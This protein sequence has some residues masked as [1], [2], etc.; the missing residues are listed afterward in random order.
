MITHLNHNVQISNTSVPGVHEE[1]GWQGSE[2][3]ARLNAV[4]GYNDLVGVDARQHTHLEGTEIKREN[5]FSL[6]TQ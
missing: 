5:S 6:S 3:A 2:N 4:S 1:A